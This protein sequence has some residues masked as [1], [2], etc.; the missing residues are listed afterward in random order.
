M[1]FGFKHWQTPASALR[2]I[3]ALYVTSPKERSVAEF[4]PV[5][6]AQAS[7]SITDELKA[8]RAAHWARVDG[9]A[10]ALK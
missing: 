6:P 10:K 1:V 9:Q 8:A 2:A 3:G 7:F 5:L 4:T